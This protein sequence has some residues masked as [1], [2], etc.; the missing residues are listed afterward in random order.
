MKES[1]SRSLLKAFSWRVFGTFSTMSITYLFTHKVDV[2][3]Y[4]G[5][6]EFVSKIALF[7]VHERM[8]N[9]MAFGLRP[10]K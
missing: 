6:F 4:V 2:T 9:G 10:L 3:L 7:Y 5:A 1:H 8:W